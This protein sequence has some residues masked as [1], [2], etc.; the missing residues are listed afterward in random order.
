MVFGSLSIGTSAQLAEKGVMFS[1]TR[2][3]VVEQAQI[4]KPENMGDVYN[5]LKIN[6]AEAQRAASKGTGAGGKRWYDH[7]AMVSAFN[8]NIFS[9]NANTFVWNMWFD[10]TVTQYFSAS[11]SNPAGYRRVNWSSMT[12]YIDP[13]TSEM[14]NDINFASEIRIKNYNAYKVDSVQVRGAYVRMKTRPAGIV[15]TLIFSVAPQNEGHYYMAKSNPDYGSEVIKYTTKDTARF[16]APLVVD[17]INRAIYAAST[18]PGGTP[19]A[20]WKVPLT[21]SD[22]DTPLASGSFTT[23]TFTYPVPGG[24]L[25][26]PAGARFAVTVTFKSGDTWTKNVDSVNKFHRFMPISGHVTD[27]E[28]IYIREL[29]K[30][31][32]MAG[33]M[34]SWDSSAYVASGLIEIWNQ[35]NFG[36]EHHAL[37][38]HVTCADC[39]PVG[40]SN[41]PNVISKVKVFPNPASTEVNVPFKLAAASDVKVSLTSLVGQVISTQSFDDV[42]MGQAVFN[43]SNLAN[44]LYFVQIVANGE[45]KVER[46]SIA[47]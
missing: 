25:N 38:A 12:Q 32:S 7:F 43:T 47:H 41:V 13:I 6:K 45:S 24:G 3:V 4:Q 2:S 11:G 23:R 39:D 27:N 20:Y 44:G 22:G 31:L 10:S 17:S 34:F 21:G 9:T 35:P 8:N 46:V 14:F 5:L 36:Y 15:D 42:T 18:L 33:M 28:M 30:D 40:V 16:C 26:I 37:S 19:R 29:Y 1:P